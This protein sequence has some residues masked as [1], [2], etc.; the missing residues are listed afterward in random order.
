MKTINHLLWVVALCL[1]GAML[2]TT[3][4]AVDAPTDATIERLLGTGSA[5]VFVNGQAQRAREGMTLHADDAIE[6]DGAIEA[7]IRVGTG[8][9]ATVKP[10][11]RLSVDALSGTESQ[12]FLAR[13]RLV[14]EIDRNRPN[15]RPYRVRTGKGIAAARGTSFTVA[16]DATGFS[17]TT[18]ADG[19]QFSTSSG[20]QIVV[21][22]GQVFY[23]APGQALSTTP[24]PL[25]TASANAAVADIL[26]DAVTTAATVVQNNIGGISADSATNI[27]AQVVAVAAG[28]LPAEA[29]TFTMQAVT[30]VTASTAATATNAGTAAA[31][32][33]SAAVSAAPAQ[34]AQIAGAAA[35]AAPE[36]AA[37]ITAAAQ[38]SAP[39]QKDAIA[40]QVSTSTGQATA[41]VQSN[42]DSA[43][44]QATRAVNSAKEATSHVLPPPGPS[45]ASAT[46]S[47]DGSQQ[48]AQNGTANQTPAN[49]VDPT[50]NVSPGT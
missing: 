40:Q 4:R 23:T 28:A 27:V 42:A 25:A 43:T 33:T 24:I 3:A 17:I 47:L 7:Y 32:I 46:P 8:V 20:A 31:T 45:G 29:A 41:A 12:L 11:S 1:A 9:V 49:P 36:H 22:A 10:N 44:T 30:A 5:T 2:A 50:L 26:R 14:N 15:A 48:G 35:Q 6:T 38:L 19:V 37:V 34:A 39:A 13:G 16:D 18:T 21:Q